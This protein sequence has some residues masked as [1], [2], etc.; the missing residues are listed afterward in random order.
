MRHL[1]GPLE[2]DDSDPKKDRLPLS[3]FSADVDTAFEEAQRTSIRAH[4]LASNF[5]LAL[6]DYELVADIAQSGI[7]LARTTEGQIGMRLPG[8][9]FRACSL[10]CS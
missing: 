4:I 8:Y 2:L 1:P 9:V 10:A 5:Y 7:F 3:T 6:K